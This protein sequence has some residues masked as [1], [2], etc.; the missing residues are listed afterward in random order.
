MRIGIINVGIGNVASIKNMLFR[1]NYNVELIEKPQEISTNFDWLILPGVGAFDS[2]IKKLKDTGWFSYLRESNCINERNTS[3]MGICLGM[4]LLT[5]GSEEGNLEGLNLIPGFFKKFTFMDKTIKVPHMGWND[6]KFFGE[7]E[8]LNTKEEDL[9]RFYFVHSYFYP[10]VDDKYVLGKTDY[11]GVFVSAI[12][13]NNSYG[14]Q[15]HPEKS[16]RYGKILF[17]EVLK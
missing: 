10:N 14:F 6:V 17:K 15:F 9:L 4:Q 11:N 3:L 12:K 7:Y 16:H 1:L 13:N 8:T 2:G 5:S